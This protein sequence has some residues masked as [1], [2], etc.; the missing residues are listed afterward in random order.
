[1]P[2]VRL[3]GKRGPAPEGAKAE[4]AP[5]APAAES[6]PEA[7]SETKASEKPSDG[8]IPISRPRRAQ[9]LP[10]T[11]PAVQAGLFL[12]DPQWAGDDKLALIM[13]WTPEQMRLAHEWARAFNDKTVDDKDVPVRPAFTV[14]GR[15]PGQEG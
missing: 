2:V 12:A 13:A 6:K 3:S 5:A 14:L 8:A 10:L 11:W 7:K 4:P 1:V 15:E 9:D